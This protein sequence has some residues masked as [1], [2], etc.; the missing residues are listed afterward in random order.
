MSNLLS[1]A[2]FDVR[3]MVRPALGIAT[4][5]T[6]AF[7]T[8]IF[9]VVGVFYFASGRA[10]PPSSPL[11]A[12]IPVS[13]VAPSVVQVF[14]CVRVGEETCPYYDQSTEYLI[15]ASPQDG[16]TYTPLKPDDPG[17]LQAD[18]TRV[19]HLTRQTPA[20]DWAAVGRAVTLDGAAT[21]KTVTEKTVTVVDA[22]TGTF[23]VPGTGQT[24]T[25]RIS[26]SQ[27][28]ITVLSVT[29]SGSR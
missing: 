2:L 16:L 17:T 11:D 20:A 24:G 19:V 10:T 29:Y 26:L 7:F 3:R 22:Q 5:A 6:V 1:N 12:K 15:Q 21:E 4:V 28:A 27:T 14:D 13:T 25:V 18:G 23:P 9:A 8:V